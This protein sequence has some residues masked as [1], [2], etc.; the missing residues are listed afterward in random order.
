[1]KHI[2]KN[3]LIYDTLIEIPWYL[4]SSSE[5]KNLACLLHRMQNGIR[6]T[7]GPLGELNYE[8]ASDVRLILVDV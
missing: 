1:M 8:M 3:E 6:L 4:M 7:I 5:Q 2:N